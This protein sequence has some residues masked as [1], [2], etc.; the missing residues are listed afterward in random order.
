MLSPVATKD[1]P[2]ER[3]A[4]P[5]PTADPLLIDLRERARA[6]ALRIGFAR[7]GFTT[8]EPLDAATERKWNLWRAA[9]RAGEMTYLMRE[10]PRRSHPRDL[11]AEART[12][13]VVMAGY[14]AGDH[15]APPAPGAG[16]VARYAWGEDY[17]HVLRGR[18]RELAGWIEA[19]AREAGALDAETPLASRP[20]VDSAPLDERALA[21][22]A[23]LGFIGKNTLLL[24][25]EYGS[26]G[27]LGILLLSLEL[28]PDAPMAPG[29]AATCGDC[30]RCIEACPTA[31]LEGPWTLDPRRCTSYLTIEQ[32]GAIPPELARRMEGWAFGC[33]ICQEVCPFNAAPLT[34]LLPEMRAEAGAGPWLTEAHLD[35]SGKQ[36]QKRWGATPLARP[37]RRGIARN[38][39]ALRE[40]GDGAPDAQ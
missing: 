29:P 38:L 8:A 30:R 31:A 37:G 21:V 15:G 10:H 27:L 22:R 23:G 2:V 28:P 40:D 7:C 25:P 24:T 35:V 11:L 36:F 3:D 14:H 5:E 33:D 16:K 12:A 9:D 26:Y 20:C 39:A 18:L 34:A 4:M 6:E 17:H 1:K 32:R 13:V 19:R